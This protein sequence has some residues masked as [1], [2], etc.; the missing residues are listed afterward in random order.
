MLTQKERVHFHFLYPVRE[1]EETMFMIFILARKTGFN[2]NFDIE[3]S[4]LD[5]Q[6]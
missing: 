3:Y 5:N 4:K 2:M 1:D 6:M